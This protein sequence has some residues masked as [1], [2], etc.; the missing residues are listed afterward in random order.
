MPKLKTRKIVAKRF[1]IKKSKKGYT[2]LKRTDGQDHFN[3]RQD[4]KT[5]RNKRSD[6]TVITHKD[7]I[8]RAVPYK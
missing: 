6:N 8:L 2:I 7:T 3:A 4:G 1:T 5:K